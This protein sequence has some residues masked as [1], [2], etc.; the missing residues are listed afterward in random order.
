MHFLQLCAGFYWSYLLGNLV[1][2]ITS[3]R[4]RDEQYYRECGQAGHMISL[5]RNDGVPIG[6]E[7]GIVLESNRVA[8]QIRYFLQAKYAHSKAGTFK[9]TLA[10]SF[11]VYEKLTPQLQ[12]YSSV[13]G[14]EQ[15]PGTGPLSFV[16]VFVSG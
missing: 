7:E 4:E 16:T 12:R 5:F 3:L 14:N 11:P 13:H 6:D 10:Q 8:K 2:V 9:S 15:I 1:S